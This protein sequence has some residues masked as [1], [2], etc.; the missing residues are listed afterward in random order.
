MDPKKAEEIILTE[1]KKNKT[2]QPTPEW[3]AT[4]GGKQDQILADAPE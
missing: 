2:D 3:Q 1:K 4:Q